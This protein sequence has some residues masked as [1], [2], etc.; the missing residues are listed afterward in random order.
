MNT[1]ARNKK[2]QADAQALK[3]ETERRLEITNLHYR[4][5]YEDE[6]EN[7]RVLFP[8]PEEPFINIPIKRGQ[9]RGL[10]KSWF[11]MFGEDKLD[12]SGQVT[13]EKVVGHFKGRITVINQ[14]EKQAFREEM[15]RNM[16]EVFSLIQQIH[17]TMFKTEMEFNSIKDIASQ[18][19]LE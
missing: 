3:V 9:A 4:K 8:D 15:E 16:N 13:N 10:K 17:H 14:A 1:L 7:N 5:F 18:E 2:N 19:K 11:T 6:L 12:E